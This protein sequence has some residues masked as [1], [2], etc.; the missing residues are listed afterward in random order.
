MASYPYLN[1]QQY[2]YAPV[3]HPVPTEIDEEEAP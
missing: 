2:S 1:Y 3:H